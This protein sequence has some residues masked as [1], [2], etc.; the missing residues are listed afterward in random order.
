DKLP[1]TYRLPLLLCYLD[2]RTRDE[3]AHQLGVKADVVRGRLERGRDKLRSRLTRRG[4]TL[5]A[6]LLSAVANPATAVDP[7][8]KVIQATLESAAT[9]CISTSV[10]SL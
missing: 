8:A 2:G 6:G 7:S 4:V 10:G 5:S 9:G 3:A 1:E